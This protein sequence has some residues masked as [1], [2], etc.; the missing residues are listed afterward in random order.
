MR[1]IR[2][3]GQFDAVVGHLP[4]VDPRS[5]GAVFVKEAV[6][7]S[8]QHQHGVLALDG[9]VVA[10]CDI[11]HTWRTADAHHGPLQ[12]QGWRHVGNRLHDL[13]VGINRRR[14]LLRRHTNTGHRVGI[15][16]GRIGNAGGQWL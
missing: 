7:V 14:A 12:L 4:S 3:V 2:A 13:Q 9:Q 10:E 8:L 1:A 6:M 11:A 15:I 5:A 16:A